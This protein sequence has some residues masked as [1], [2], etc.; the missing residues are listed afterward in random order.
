[1]PRLIL[2]HTTD[3]SIKV[4]VRG[5]RRWPVAF[6]DILDGAGTKAGATR[7]VELEEDDFYTGVARCT[8]LKANRRY[9]ARVAFG[10]TRQTPEEERIREAYTEGSFSTFPASGKPEFRFLL[11]SCNLHS[12][13]IFEKP[14]KAWVR[15]SNVAARTQAK[16]MI[17]CGDQI[18]ADIPLPPLA[19]Y[20]HYRDK[21]LDA[22][23]DCK[24][25]QRVLTELPHYM[26]L[27]DHEIDNDY[28]GSEW[29]DGDNLLNVAMKV[30][31]E[32]QH[33][34]NPDTRPLRGQRRYHYNFSFGDVQFY[35]LDTRYQRRS[36]RG[37]II[38]PTQLSTFKRWLKTH[39][40]ALKFVITSVPFVSQVKRNHDDKWC[41]P[42][43]DHQ[44]ADILRHMLKEGVTDTVFLT[45]DMHTSCKAGMTFSDGTLTGTVHE[46][47]SSPINQ[48]TPDTSL[49]QKFIPDHKATIDGIDIHSRIDPESFYGDHSN[50]MAVEVSGGKVNYQIYRTTKNETGP[51]GSL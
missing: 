9:K 29:G 8:G 41:A 44:R 51:A 21:Y 39:K 33:K 28:D 25:A 2:G 35:A 42:A 20:S 45:G 3:R 24:P 18:Y 16:F 43:Y 4:W 47:M 30:Y 50:V 7:I 23:R 32:F 10:K 6:V 17:H 26:I 31:Y 11:G 19:R 13:G 36:D 27:D 1:M 49:R 12:L 5:S 38:D 22:W 40:K 46:L 48:F 34:H 15:I 37:E 14:D